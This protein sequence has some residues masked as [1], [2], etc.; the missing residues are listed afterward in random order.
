MSTFANAKATHIYSAKVLA[1]MPYLIKDLTTLS[2]NWTL[3][4][5][6]EKPDQLNWLYTAK[7]VTEL[8]WCSILCLVHVPVY[9]IILL[10]VSKFTSMICLLQFGMFE[11]VTSAFVD[12][13][14]E[15]LT[16]RRTFVNIGTGVFMFL[17]CIPF[18][19]PVSYPKHNY[20]NKSMWNIYL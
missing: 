19:C 1:Y 8:I 5:R 15:Q 17:I 7:I 4:I 20:V 10:M 11:T 18:A 6:S 9:L 16:K 3:I 14:P 13:F 12:V 2:N